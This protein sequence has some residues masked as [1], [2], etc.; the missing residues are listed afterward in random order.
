MHCTAEHEE[1]RELEAYPMG[2]GVAEEQEER[3]VP[4]GLLKPG[5]TKTLNPKP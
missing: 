4:H 3:G 2:D 5:L 1:R